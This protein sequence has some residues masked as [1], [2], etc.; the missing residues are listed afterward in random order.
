M[1]SERPLVEALQKFVEKEPYSLHVPGHKNGRLSTLPKELKNALIYDVTELSGLD[2]FHHPEEAIDAAQKLLAE[3]YGADRSF[4]L[5]NGS[6]VGNLAMVYAVCRHGDTILVQ[7]NAHKSIFHAIELVGA[8]PVY[9]APEWD[10]H[11]RSA[12]A[13]PLET[14][15][16]AVKEYPEAKGLILTYPTYYGVVAKDLQE[17]IKLCHAKQI[18]VLVDEAHG[19]H[20]TASKEFPISALDLGADI[21]VHSAHKTLPAMTMASFMHI[22]SKLISD[23]R[24]NHYLRM[25]QSS[26]PSY[27]LLASLDDAR[28]YISKYKESDALYCLEKRKQ[29]LEALE[30]IPELEIMEADDPL[31]VCIRMPGYTGMELKA[32]MEENLLYPELADIEQ[33]LLVLPLLKR[34]EVY[35]YADIQIRMKQVVAQLKMKKGSEQPQLG[36]QYKMASIT[37]PNVTFAELEAKE[38]EWVPYAHS[39]GRIAGSMLIPYPPGIPLFVPGEKITVSKLSQLEELLAGG[40]AFQGEHR[41]EERFIQVL[42]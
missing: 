11:T 21:V 20:F 2:D 35:P 9:L 42:K 12:G 33:V 24:I 6:T 30:S 4:F 41:L 1:K 26:S 40:A 16:E 17:Q 25:L 18:P 37:T 5:V 32:A 36:K 34:G 13:V 38:K 3:T 23:Q 29:W 7:R 14:I 27:L 15:K 28:H 19:A 31:K 39:I 10:E 8:K 22:K